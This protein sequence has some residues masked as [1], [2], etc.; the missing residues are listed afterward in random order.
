[1]TKPKK[2]KTVK[3]VVASV[4]NCGRGIRISIKG[5]LGCTLLERTFCGLP[6]PDN[7]QSTTKLAR[8]KLFRIESTLGESTPG[9][10]AR[11]NDIQSSNWSA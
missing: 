5:G 8:L 3:I 6:R 2:E 4:Y 10:L 9:L 11:V 1:M 7:S